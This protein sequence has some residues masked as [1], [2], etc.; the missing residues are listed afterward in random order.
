[1]SMFKIKT[2]SLSIL[3]LLI[4]PG[5][6]SVAT[7]AVIEKT[8]LPLKVGYANDAWR[9]CDGDNAE[10]CLRPTRK[11]IYIPD[12]NPITVKQATQ[13]VINFKTERQSIALSFKRFNTELSSIERIKLKARLAE[14]PQNSEV[15]VIGYVDQTGNIKANTKLALKRAQRIQAWMVSH[16]IKG[17]LVVKISAPDKRCLEC[18]SQE[19][20]HSSPR[21]VE[22]VFFINREVI[23]K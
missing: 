21:W 9:L 11:T 6:S 12:Q 17:K 18:A 2:A 20:E 19:P 23:S 1:M 7:T 4:L 22:V 15:T 10:G 3:A 5:C 13:P 16:G 14:I 8:A